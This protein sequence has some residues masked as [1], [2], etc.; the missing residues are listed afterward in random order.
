MIIQFYHYSYDS[1]SIYDGPSNAS[2]RVGKYC[3]NSLPPEFKSTTNEVL[4]YFKSDGIAQRKGFKL[5]Y[6]SV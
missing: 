5:E 6:E 2:P 4:I 3:G 1:V